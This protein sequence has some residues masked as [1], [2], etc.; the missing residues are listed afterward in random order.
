MNDLISPDM[1]LKEVVPR[2][3]RPPWVILRT[4]CNILRKSTLPEINL[5]PGYHAHCDLKRLGNNPKLSHFLG[6]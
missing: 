1:A 3:Q 2:R 6:I 5:R 4:H